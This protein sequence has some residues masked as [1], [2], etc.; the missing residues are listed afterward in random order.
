MN[1]TADNFLVSNFRSYVQIAKQNQNSFG[2]QL[3]PTKKNLSKC[4]C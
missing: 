2:I 4:M 1:N 3:I